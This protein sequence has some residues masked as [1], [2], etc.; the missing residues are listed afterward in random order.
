MKNTSPPQ[1]DNVTYLEPYQGFRVKI[2]LQCT[3][4]NNQWTT[5]PQVVQQA[6][7]RGHNGC[8]AC[9]HNRRY[10]AIQ[11][12]NI[13]SLPQHIVPEPRWDGTRNFTRGKFWFTNTD[14][15]HRFETYPNYVLSGHTEC[16]I[17][18]DL[19]RQFKRDKNNNARKVHD[20]E[21]WKRYQNDCHYMSDKVFKLNESL[22]NP[23]GH[24]R[25]LA[26]VPGGHQLD[27][28]LPKAVGYS[29]GIPPD[30]MSHI[31]NLQYIPWEDN[32]QHSAT[33]KFIPLIFRQY[34][35]SEYLEVNSIVIDDLTSFEFE[36][37]DGLR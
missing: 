36:L 9:K 3:V 18:G 29:L 24:P 28:I 32:R 37:E 21:S 22:L 12:A 17:C 8:P 30:L 33:I 35:T 19:I 25:T 20:P 11:A 27:H 34:F 5:T 7:R 14:C 10:G 23:H 16:T 2:L 13:A 4:C 26:G 1:Y 6:N 31:D 15:G